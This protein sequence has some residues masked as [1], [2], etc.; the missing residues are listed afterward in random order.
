MANR[1]HTPTVERFRE[2][3]VPGRVND[4]WPWHANQNGMGYGLLWDYERRRKVLAH[5]YAYELHH[6]TILPP[7]QG[8]IIMHTCDNP[9]CVNPAHLQR[10]TMKDNYADMTAKGRR[11]IAWSPTNIPPHHVGSKHPHAK[12]TEAKVLQIRVDIANGEPTRAV[13]RRLGMNAST[14]RRI[15]DRKTWTHI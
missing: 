7:G 9:I 12:L 10:G 8:I 4:C 3:F 1:K 14:I 11:K 15:R 13:A 5:R 2:K 6:G